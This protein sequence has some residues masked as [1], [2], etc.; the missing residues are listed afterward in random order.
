MFSPFAGT[1]VY[2]FLQYQLWMILRG[3]TSRNFINSANETFKWEDLGIAIS[4]RQI[5]TISPYVLKFNQDYQPGETLD[6]YLPRIKVS[7]ASSKANQ[8]RGRVDFNPEEKEIPL[9]SIADLRNIYDRN[10]YRN[11]LEMFFPKSLIE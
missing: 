11:I 3:V 1:V 6:D 5:T 8:R 2:L 7:K 4:S 9:E 10:A